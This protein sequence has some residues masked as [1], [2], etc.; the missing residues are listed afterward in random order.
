MA[1]LSRRPGNRRSR[2]PG[3]WAFFSSPASYVP[4]V[5]AAAPILSHTATVGL[6]LTLFLIG[7]GLSAST[8]RRVGWRPL[9]Q[10][11]LL[12]V[13]ISMASLGIIMRFV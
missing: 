13:F 11:V 8:L 2:C 9:L 6:S 7:A 5:K 4:G 10:G 12:W 3:S 1:A